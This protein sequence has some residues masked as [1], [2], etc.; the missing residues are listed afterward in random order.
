MILIQNGRLHLES[1]EV[2]KADILIKDR[3][4]AAIG[5][6]L[7]ADGAVVLNAEGLDVFPGL[8]VPSCNIGARGVAILRDKDDT[9][10]ADPINPQMHIRYSFDFR[11]VKMQ[12]MTRL[13]ITSYGLSPG[14][15]P[16]VAGQMA[17]VN[18]DAESASDAILVDNVA[19][20]GNFN[21]SVMDYY[22]G[23][24]KMPTTHMGMYYLLDK[25]LTD[26]RAYMEQDNPPYQQ[27]HA[28][29]AAMLRGEIPFLVN[30]YAQMDIECIL[31]LAKKH[32]FRPVFC[33]AFAIEQC[34]EQIM[35][36]GYYAA[37]GE[38]TYLFN[39]VNYNTN[40]KRLVELYRKGLRLCLATGGEEG[41]P[42]AYDQLMWSA[43]MLRQAGASA[44]EVLDMMT[45]QTARAL[46]VDRLV[47]SIREGKQADLMICAGNPA[48]SYRN[49]VCAT[50][51]AG[52]ISYRKD[53]ETACF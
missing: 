34:A 33:G 4:I 14:M 52:R 27:K 37:V 12:H 51:V 38:F 53:D 2:K 32:G 3:I 13:G 9:E 25:A 36:A 5:V 47:G 45:I 29:F 35:D 28:E 39:Y 43:V 50:I 26:A 41:Y 48:E 21:R 11:E 24:R 10:D 17:L 23:K 19:M 40:L 7:S 8:I 42:P 44:Q 20:K 16:L 46:G 15:T 31:R 6:H 18:T 1:G 22:A 49:H 30:A